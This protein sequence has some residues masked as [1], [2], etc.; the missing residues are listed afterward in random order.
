MSDE[1]EARSAAEHEARLRD[2]GLSQAAQRLSAVRH[3]IKLISWTPGLTDSE[4][5]EVHALTNT[6]ENVFWH[7]EQALLAERKAGKL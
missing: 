5:Q 4:A 1:V 7:L 3:E 2:H 6:I